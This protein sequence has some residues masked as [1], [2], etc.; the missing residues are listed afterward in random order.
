MPEILLEEGARILPGFLTG[1]GVGEDTVAGMAAT[2]A[3]GLH[4]A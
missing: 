2:D 4:A 1:F 3:G